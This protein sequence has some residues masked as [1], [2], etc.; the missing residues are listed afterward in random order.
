MTVDSV[1]ISRGPGE[2]RVALLSDGRLKE[3][4]VYR[5]GAP[6]V[7]GNIYLGRVEAVN[8]GIEAA[9][10]DIGLG[11]SGFLAL[12]EA[13][14]AS[15]EGGPGDHIADYVNEGDAVLVQVLRD[16]AGDKGAKLTT[17][18]NLAG[19]NLVFRPGHPGVSIS[20][21]IEDEGE[22]GRLTAV[23]EALAP[24]GDG[25]IVRTAA[26]GAAEDALETEAR[27][28]ARR[29]KDIRLRR[30]NAKAPSALSE[31]PGPALRALRDHGPGIERIVADDSE[32]LN[33]VREYCA[34]ELPALAAAVEAHQGK[35]AL[36]EA[37]GVEEQIDDALSPAVALPG[38]GSLIISQTP[39]LCAIDV[40]TGGADGG[41]KE[42]TALSVDLEATAEAARQIRLRNISGLI[43][44]DFVPV[45]GP[46]H[47]AEVLAALRAA[48]AADSLSPHVVGYTAMGLV[49]MT[50][51]RHGPSLREILCLPFGDRA[52]PS[53]SPLTVALA[54]LRG[55]LGEGQG[56]SVPLTLRASPA[57][58]GALRGPA[59]AAL[60]EAE[61]RLGLAITAV[62]DQTFAAERWEI[63]PA[64]DA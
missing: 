56:T 15:A 26:S 34:A 8:K 22:R 23:V 33:E 21:R 45:R 4:L 35:Q 57:V 27:A 20:R 51:R 28:L 43:V 18:V 32:A 63:V 41:S 2:T 9:F 42:Q 7:A 55:V 10:V 59:K 38:G 6:G 31:E 60:K 25:F 30:A 52:G 16:P 12:P 58:I 50:R 11:R 39:A 24:E 19:V 47:K 61:R 36:F 46:G 1:L 14:P 53:K 44:V 48:V 29:W 37:F 13:R 3:L 17:Q 5:E 62:A 64:K 54:A 40:N 49:E